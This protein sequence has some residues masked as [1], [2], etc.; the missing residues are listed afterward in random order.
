MFFLSGAFPETSP[1]SAE[2]KGRHELQNGCYTEKR[3]HDNAY[4][5]GVLGDPV[6]L[7]KKLCVFSFPETAHCI[8]FLLPGEQAITLEGSAVIQVLL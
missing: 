8:T 2:E 3:L 6:S 5:G 7:F 4:H 1:P